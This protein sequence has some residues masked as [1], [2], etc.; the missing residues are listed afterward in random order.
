MLL[1][2]ALGARGASVGVASD[3]A[4]LAS[5]LKQT[6]YDAA[7]VDLS[8]L[9]NPREALIKLHAVA[10]STRLVLM[11]GSACAPEPGVLAQVAAWVRKPFEIGELVEALLSADP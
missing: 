4:T 8:P 9:R 1:E 7:L 2:T 11:T 10:P 3:E 5:M 6:G